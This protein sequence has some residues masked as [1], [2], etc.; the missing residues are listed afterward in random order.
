MTITQNDVASSQSSRRLDRA[1]WLLLFVLTAG[2][3]WFA[4]TH[5]LLQDEAYYWQWSRHLDWGY[6]DN[7][8][9]AA[10]LI[11]FFTSIFG[12]TSL[13]VRA[14][15][16]FCAL[17][18]SIFIY[19]LGKRLFGPRVGF[20]ALLLANFI[21]LFGAGAIIMTMDPPQLAIW[22]MALYVIWS[23]VKS[24][25][26]K[27]TALWLFA[28][29][30]AGLAAMAKVYALLLLPCIL[31]FL[32]VSPDDRHW[33]RRWQPYGA[34][35]IALAVFAPFLWWAHTHGNAF[36]MHVG[37]M[38]AR[39]GDEHDKPLKYFWRDLGAQALLLSPIFYLTYIYSLFTE[40]KRGLREK[41]SALL[42]AW[43]PSATVTGAVMLLSMRTKVEGNW[44]AAA[45]V[46]GAILLA[47]VLVRMW[48]S[49]T[50]SKRVWVMTGAV[51]ATFLTIVFYAPQLFYPSFGRAS[52]SSEK[53][54]RAVMKLDRPNEAYGWMA[55]GSR[56]QVEIS[57]MGTNPFVFG[58][59]YKIPSE[60]AFYL[61]GRPQ[62]YSLFLNDRANEYM[63]W[64]DQSKLVGRDAIYINDS[65][66]VQDHLD[67]IKAVFTRVEP[68]AP[69][70][71]RR[72]PPYGHVPIR[73]IQIVRCYG[74]KGYDV[75]KWQHGW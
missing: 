51:L 73:T 48:D 26:G 67:D 29:V 70:V 3:L 8:P 47:V 37:V 25:G 14:G 40:V 28:G 49:G 21:P 19:L 31:V 71:I 64:E 34:A 4:A 38:G 75:S 56:V 23:A 11:H 68:Q 5:D 30:L 13:G 50:R 44:A 35:V 65:D 6:Y 27:G 43:A 72:D 32:A 69:L 58:T 54:E 66:N 62:T 55:L 24:E 74:F 60:A 16:V 22:S 46:S 61:P 57:G 41:D 36:W 18:A 53:T 1:A 2:R 45:Y 10:P 20:V 42:F 63:F 15:A 33:L 59:N 9:L 7:T 39:G 52:F 17:T 12:D